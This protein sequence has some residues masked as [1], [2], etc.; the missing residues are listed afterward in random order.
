MLC[1]D[2]QLT[3]WRSTK[4]D[5]VSVR[6]TFYVLCCGNVLPQSK[7]NGLENHPDPLWRKGR[8][9]TIPGRSR[10][11]WFSRHLTDLSRVNK[12]CNVITE[13]MSWSILAENWLNPHKR[14]TNAQNDHD[15]VHHHEGVLF[16]EI[17]RLQTYWELET[18]KFFISA[19]STSS[20]C[21]SKDKF[22]SMIFASTRWSSWTIP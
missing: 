10:G 9:K 19:M 11:P 4:N 17:V 2:P 3:N 8:F 6:W 13:M 21:S 16:R 22:L 14:R 12:L 5:V 20:T 7:R 18:A 15:Q 1:G